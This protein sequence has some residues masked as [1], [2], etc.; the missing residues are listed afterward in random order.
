MY[1]QPH[2]ALVDTMREFTYEKTQFSRTRK[3]VFVKEYTLVESSFELVYIFLRLSSVA[4]IG[5]VN[6]C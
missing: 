1:S 4:K 5:S 6:E 3:L 2:K